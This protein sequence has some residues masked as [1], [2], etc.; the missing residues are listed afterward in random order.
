MIKYGPQNSPDGLDNVASAYQ[1][2]A[3]LNT[4]KDKVR[5]TYA[6]YGRTGFNYTGGRTCVPSTDGSPYPNCTE[7]AP[8]DAPSIQWHF[9]KDNTPAASSFTAASVSITCKVNNALL[10]NKDTA[11]MAP[12]PND[13]ACFPASARIITPAGPKPIAQLAVGDKVLAV[14]AATGKAVFDVVYLM[15]HRD[16]ESAATY[17]NIRATPV[18]AEGDSKV[19]TLSPLH[20]MPTV[21]GAAQQQ[22]C[23]KHA[24][25]VAVGDLVWLLQGQHAEL[26]R[27]DEVSCTHQHNSNVKAVQAACSCSLFLQLILTVELPVVEC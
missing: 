20:Y 4:L 18:A 17:L 7:A 3:K 8:F 1:L 27:V 5:C 2:P 9:D 6:L 19:L 22:Q 21:C 26:A 15:P 23:L 25:E 16:T 24:R 13:G 14:D 10:N 12:F 11:L